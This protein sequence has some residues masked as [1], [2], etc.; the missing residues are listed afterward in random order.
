M[1]EHADWLIEREFEAYLC[2]DDEYEEE[3]V[4]DKAA[5]IFWEFIKEELYV[6]E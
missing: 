2:Q 6:I 4:N 3:R 1:G 5:Q